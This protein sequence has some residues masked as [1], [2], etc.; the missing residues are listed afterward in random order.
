MK[1]DKILKVLT[2]IAAC[3]LLYT[4]I[5]MVLILVQQ[6]EYRESIKLSFPNYFSDLIISICSVLLLAISTF[7]IMVSEHRNKFKTPKVV[8]MSLL[9]ILQCIVSSDSLLMFKDNHYIGIMLYL[10]KYQPWYYICLY[11]SSL[12]YLAAII[13]YAFNNIILN[14]KLR[15]F[16]RYFCLISSLTSFVLNW[17]ITLSDLNIPKRY[18]SASR[19]VS[20]LEQLSVILIL[21]YGTKKIDTPLSEYI[22]LKLPKRIKLIRTEKPIYT[23]E[24]VTIQQVSINTDSPVIEKQPETIEIENARSIKISLKFVFIT[25]LFAFIAFCTSYTIE[26]D[27]LYNKFSWL[28]IGIISFY[29]FIYIL[30]LILIDRKKQINKALRKAKTALLIVSGAV[31]ITSATLYIAE[32]AEERN[33]SKM[34]SSINSASKEN[35]EVIYFKDNTT[36]TVLNRKT[37]CGSEFTSPFYSSKRSLYFGKVNKGS[38]YIKIIVQN[39][40]EIE[41]HPYNSDSVL[42]TVNKAKGIDVTYLLKSYNFDRYREELYDVSRFGVL[43]DNYE[44]ISSEA[45]KELAN[46]SLLSLEDIAYSS[47]YIDDRLFCR[48]NETYAHVKYLGGMDSEYYKDGY[49]YTTDYSEG[50]F[51][52]KYSFNSDLYLQKETEYLDKIKEILKLNSDDF[53][54]KDS[55]LTEKYTIYL[56]KVLTIK[57]ITAR[58]YIE[59]TFIAKELLTVTLSYDDNIFSVKTL[60]ELGDNFDIYIYLKYPHN[61]DTYKLKR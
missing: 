37:G 29:L 52:V 20:I 57:G 3:F 56:D 21:I 24:P 8:I 55:Y 2:I 5:D 15:K 23:D 58:Y 28:N 10:G 39:K 11:I 35:I 59:M 40:Y 48:H 61:I 54:I 13:L 22:E 60:R 53:K 47:Q 49:L 1:R 12:T 31:L 43:K 25:S 17:V 30:T 42:M 46:N 32:R 19:T 38:E 18:L 4:F 45:K 9:I 26:G 33:F 6:Y 50:N 14:A 16:S 27:S 34:Y 7:A 41:I 36:T 51:K 44:D